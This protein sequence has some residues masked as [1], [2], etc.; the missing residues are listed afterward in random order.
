MS[1]R[2]FAWFAQTKTALGRQKR[3]GSRSGW[4]SGAAVHHQ[5]ETDQ[6]H[7]GWTKSP[8]IWSKVSLGQ[9]ADVTRLLVLVAVTGGSRTLR[10]VKVRASARLDHA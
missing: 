8:S 2:G 6:D 4:S 3:S 7:R 5:C 1:N 10:Q 9:A